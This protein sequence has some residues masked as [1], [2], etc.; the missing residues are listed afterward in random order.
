MKIECFVLLTACLVPAVGPSGDA[1]RSAAG[2]AG[3]ELPKAIQKTSVLS[4]YAF[5][6]EERPGKGT[7]GTV[8]GKYQK[9]QPLSL[10]ADQIEF[11]KKGDALVYKY[12][13]QWSKTRRGIQSDPLIVLGA[14][15]KAG[16]VRPPHE[17]IAGFDKYLKDPHRADQKEK[18]CSVYTGALTPDAAAK[19]APSEYRSVARGG[20]AKLWISRDGVIVQYAITLRLQGQLGNA[21]IDGTST[22]KVVLTDVNATR[23]VVPEGAKKAIE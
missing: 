16:G 9:G 1:P 18:D 22:R 21:V 4:S 13:D 17:E 12:K 6:V 7:G 8:E 11:F 19:L 3:G 10:K 14:S 2:Q 20:T 15:A 23:V 5:T